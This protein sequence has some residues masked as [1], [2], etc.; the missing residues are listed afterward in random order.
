LQRHAFAAQFPV[1]H[2]AI[3]LDPLRRR[4]RRSRRQDAPLKLILFQWFGRSPIEP[5]GSGE[6]KV[7][8]DRPEADTE[9]ALYLSVR[10][11]ACPLQAEHFFDS[12]H[13]R[14]VSRHRR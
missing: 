12:A 6:L 3:W 9:R 2:V 10:E 1:D 4:R 7:L 5:R 11:I 14:P 8:G 13:G